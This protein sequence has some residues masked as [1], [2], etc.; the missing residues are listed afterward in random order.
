MLFSNNNRLNL[1]LAANFN[2]TEV[3]ELNVPPAFQQ[4]D[5]VD[6]RDIVFLTDGIPKRK[7]IGSV[8]YRM[9]KLGVLLRMTNFGEVQD[10]RETDPDTDAPQ[11]FA[12]KSV[13]DL[14][15][16]GYL[17]PQLTITAGV[18]NL[19][20]TYPDML[21]SPN[22]RGEVIYSRRTNQFGTQGR[23]LNLSLNYTW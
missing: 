12:S 9:G 20:D 10:A 11:V 13:V 7:I 18:N 23:F 21:I 2:D 1:A 6:D 17:A 3:D 8:S 15:F 4:S 14:A 16:T 22:V 19:L 5:I